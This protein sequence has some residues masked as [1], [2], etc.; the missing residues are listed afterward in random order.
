[1]EVSD[2]I[3]GYS[4]LMSNAP[5]KL[6]AINKE[7][8]VAYFVEKKDFLETVQDS[9]LDCEYYFEMKTKIDSMTYPDSW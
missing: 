1:M 5:I 7:F 4:F 2:N 3:Y 9:H 8:V 6:T